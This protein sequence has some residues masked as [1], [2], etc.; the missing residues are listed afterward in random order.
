VSRASFSKKATA[1][2]SVLL[3]RILQ[4]GP[5]NVYPWSSAH[6][7]SFDVP[8]L[9]PR[10]QR[11]LFSC[12]ISACTSHLG[13]DLVEDPPDG[14]CDLASHVQGQ[15]DVDGETSPILHAV[16]EDK[17]VGGEPE[18]SGEDDG[19]V[20][21]P[22]R[23][24]CGRL[25][26]MANSRGLSGFDLILAEVGLCIVVVAVML[27]WIDYGMCAELLRSEEFAG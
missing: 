1:S 13:I 10:S 5:S 16:Q 19:E 20:D 17:H 4:T 9:Y 3:N 24:H 2:S 7:L 26:S 8:Y 14:S 25:V 15:G 23:R 11:S 21:L 6:G 18:D 27:R 22:E 12:I